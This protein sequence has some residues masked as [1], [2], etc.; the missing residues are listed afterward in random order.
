MKT[1][2]AEEF[3][4]QAEI[5]REVFTKWWKCEFGDLFAYIE[6]EKR[7]K[8]YTDIHCINMDL[9]GNI[10]GN[11]EYLKTVAIPILTSEQLI[12]FI[13][14]M[15]GQT[16][17]IEKYN[18]RKGKADIVVR[19]YE[20]NREVRSI[21]YYDYESVVKALWKYATVQVAIEC[22]LKEDN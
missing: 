22:I 5:I 17:R 2:S 8:G 4:I 11:W 15:T 1:I 10:E 18:P 19:I 7:D 14:E 12:D 21:M 6:E 20:N 3:M 16:V 9:E 13:E